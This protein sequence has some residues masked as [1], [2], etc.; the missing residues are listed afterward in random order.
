MYKSYLLKYQGTG[1]CFYIGAPIINSL[2]NRSCNMN[3]LRE[4]GIVWRIGSVF[5]RVRYHGISAFHSNLQG[6]TNIS[7]TNFQH[8]PSQ[9]SK[10]RF[11]SLRVPEVGRHCIAR[12][13]KA[14]TPPWS[15]SWLPVPTSTPWTTVFSA[16]SELEESTRILH[17]FVGIWPQN[18]IIFVRVC[19]NSLKLWWDVVGKGR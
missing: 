3:T 15:G 18:I 5:E 7:F 10:K 19:L 16:A 14:M 6:S 11:P 13:R 12:R 1:T 9:Q 4:D 2:K 8:L 17:K